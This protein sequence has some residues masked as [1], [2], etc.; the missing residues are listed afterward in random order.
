MDVYYELLCTIQFKED[1]SVNQVQSSLAKFISNG[2]LFTQELKE[3][4]EQN[5]YK[6]Y[7]FSLPYPRENDRIYRQNRIYCFNLRTTKLDFAVAMK[8]YLPKAQGNVRTFAI[9]LRNY[10]QP[11]ISELISLTPIICTVENR[12]W[13]PENGLALLASRLHINAVKKCKVQNAN[14]VEP[15]EYFFELIELI[16]KKPIGMSYKGT[17]LLGHKVQLKIKPQQWAQQLAFT[18]L[19]QGLGEKN[20]IGFGYCLARR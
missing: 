19:G 13:M 16:N 14:F 10:T 8:N 2:M 15:D 1:I 3:M 7:V 6:P 18:V 12:C 17:T 20:A 9:E 5:I 4:H 11:F